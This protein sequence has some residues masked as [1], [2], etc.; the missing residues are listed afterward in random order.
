MPLVVISVT[1]ERLGD[2]EYT[3]ETHTS[4][5]GN[6]LTAYPEEDYLTGILDTGASSHLINYDDAQK[7]GLFYND[8]LT[9]NTIE[10][11]GV[12]GTANA[13]VSYPI[14]LFADGVQRL[15]QNGYLTDL[16]NMVG[17]SN[18]AVAVGMGYD[19][20]LPTVIGTPMTVYWDTVIMNDQPTEVNY[21]D[22]IQVTPEIKILPKDS[23]DV[24][25]Y[26]NSLPLELRP[27]GAVNVQYIPDLM[28]DDLGY[29]PMQPSIIT[30]E[31][32]QSLFFVHTVDLYNK[33]EEAIDKDRFMFDTGAQVTV[34]GSRIAAR[35]RLDTENPDFEVEILDVTGQITYLPG[36]FI[37]SLEMPALG[38]WLTFN[39]VPVILLDVPSPEGGTL[40][41]IIGMNLF[42]NYNLVLKGGGLFGQLDPALEFEPIPSPIPG[43]IAPEIQDGIVDLK[44]LK[45]FC[46]AWLSDP[47][48]DNWNKRA[49]FNVDAMVNLKDYELFSSYYK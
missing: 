4:I 12:N 22:N 7:A 29:A 42:N 30:G 33:G 28:A 16:T 35:L 38:Q 14:A 6:H 40:D 43:D 49:D 27:L 47:T 1:D 9:D 37:E 24:P 20:V 3:A 46:N 13:Y 2:L 17:E 26:N 41:G 21:N 36:F 19:Q 32:A 25:D 39:D 18:V 11:L 15:D 48:E 44:D 5:V 31:S 10:I 45:A 34:V 8:K 23:T